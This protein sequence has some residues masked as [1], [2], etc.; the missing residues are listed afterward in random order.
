MKIYP[1]K[2]ERNETSQD[3]IV[4]F[5]ARCKVNGNEI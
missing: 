3:V 4:V 2:T 5:L 1:E